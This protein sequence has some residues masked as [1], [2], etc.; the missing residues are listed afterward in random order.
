V[1]DAGAYGEQLARTLADRFKVSL[2][3]AR[4]QVTNALKN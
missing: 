2:A 1:T 4:N 3:L